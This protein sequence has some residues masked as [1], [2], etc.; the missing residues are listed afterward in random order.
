MPIIARGEGAYVYDEHGKRYLDGLSALFCVNA[1][2]GAHRA[3]RG[4]G[5][6]GRGAR[7][8]HHLELRAPA[9][10]RA[11]RAD[12]VA[13]ARRPQP[14]LLHLRRL[15]GGRVGDQARARLPPAHRQ[16]PQ[17]QVPDPRDRLPRDH[18]GRPAGDRDPG[19]A[20]RLRAA[21]PGRDQGPEHQ[22]LPLA[23]GPRSALG[24][25]PDRGEDPLRGPRDGRRR[26]P[27]AA[28]ERRRLHP[29]PGRLL[30]ARARDLRPPRRAAG[31]RRGDLRLGPAR[32]LVRLPA[33]RL[34]ARHRHHGEGADL[35]LR[36]DGGDDRLRPRL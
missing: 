31:L 16:P 3:R 24:G 22:Q 28:P 20:H 5:T 29:A 18:A 25:G 9:R 33:L 12:R 26:D 36:A 10:D 17:D 34:S 21:G 11:R 32:P 2:H 6:P 13:D 35:R 1:G 8:L 19:A 23:R 7:L 27:R 30:P 15:G 14:G 4:G